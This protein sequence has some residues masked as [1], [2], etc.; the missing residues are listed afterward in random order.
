MKYI[1]FNQDTLSKLSLGT[2]QFGLNYGIANNSGQPAQSMVNNII[3]YVYAQGVNCFDTAQDYGESEIVLNQGLQAKNNTFVISKLKS[4]IFKENASN[5]VL[6]SLDHLGI[7]SLYALL[8]HDSKLLYTWSQKD[9]LTVKTLIK[10]NTIKHF[11]VSIY[12]SEDFET[13]LKNDVI[14]FIQIPFNLFDQRAVTQ[15]W[16]QKAKKHNKLLFIRSVFLQGLLLMD[17]DKIPRKLESAK[18]NIKIMNLMCEELNI[19]KSQLALNFVDTVATDS[20][21]LFGCETM[22]QAQENLENYEKMEPLDASIIKRLMKQ[23]ADVDEK[24]YNPSRW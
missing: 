17:I 13:A 14:E 15:Q 19:S 11:G 6:K 24:I 4:D 5:S 8:L 23:F 12:T 21:I 18:K 2:V 22:E 3:N 1:V 16:F 20:L 7:D 10:N 9:A